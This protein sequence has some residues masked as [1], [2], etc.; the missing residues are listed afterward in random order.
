MLTAIFTWLF[1]FNG[2]T[3]NTSLITREPVRRCVMIASPHTS[4]W[5]LVYLV[6]AFRLMQIP[7]RFTIKK[8]WMRAPFSWFIG[9][10][11][12][13]AIDR[14]PRQAGQERLSMTDAMASLFEENRDLVVIVTPEGTRSK[15]TEWKT[16][17]YYTALKAGVPI[18]LGYLDYQKKEAG[19]GLRID[20]SGDLAADMRT[21]CAFYANIVP[22]HPQNFSPDLRYWP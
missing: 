15:R 4:N 17:F 16:G 5:D 13:I 10:L 2:W 8:E 11:G 7:L 14:S 22:C 1:R 20:P 19:V 3:L 12:A 6:A 9:P 21:I 18:Y